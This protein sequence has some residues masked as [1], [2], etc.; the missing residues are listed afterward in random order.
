[1]SNPPSPRG[2]PWGSPQFPVPPLPDGARTVPLPPPHIRFW[3][4]VD[5]NG[6]FSP[7]FGCLEPRQVPWGEGWA[8]LHLSCH[9]CPGAGEETPEKN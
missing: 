7:R 5:R 8:R 2:V 1:M 6:L 4:E 3:G 9:F